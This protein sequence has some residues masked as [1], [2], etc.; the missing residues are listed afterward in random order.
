LNETIRKVIADSEWSFNDICIVFVNIFHLVR[1]LT[2]NGV[3]AEAR[4]E[5]ILFVVER[6][7]QKI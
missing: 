1:I 2:V 5:A 7:F 6:L 3:L 4:G